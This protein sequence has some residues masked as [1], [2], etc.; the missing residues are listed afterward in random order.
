[1]GA[2]EYLCIGSGQ[3]IKECYGC[4]VNERL[5]RMRCGKYVCF[6]CKK[7]GVKDTSIT[8]KHKKLIN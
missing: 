2:C 1:M 8:I 6:L 3:I 5:I 4:G 7:N